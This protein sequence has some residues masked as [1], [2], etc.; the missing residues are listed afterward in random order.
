MSAK[1]RAPASTTRLRSTVVASTTGPLALAALGA[2]AA[3]AAQAAP[4]VNWD[5]VAQCESSGNWA[6]NTGN[7]FYG[8]LQFTQ[9]TWKA[10]GGSGSPQGASREEQIA[11]AER[12]LDGQGIKAWPVCGSHGLGGHTSNVGSSSSSTGHTS[13][14]KKSSGTHRS[15]PAPSSGGYTVVSGDTLSSIAS[16]HGVSGGWRALAAANQ[17]VSTNPN[18]IMPGQHLTMPG[19]STT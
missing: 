5:A 16:S 10:F 2:V 3:P 8:G 17:G 13:T 15:T 4:S 1:H 19:D 9:S 6:A 14:P 7:G 12:V 18:M 11:V